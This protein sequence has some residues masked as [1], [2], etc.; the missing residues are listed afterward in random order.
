VPIEPSRPVIIGVDG[1]AGPGAVDLAAEEAGRRGVGLIIMHACGRSA[2]DVERG[3]RV[4]ESARARVRTFDLPVT[5]E[6]AHGEPAEE[7]AGRS[8][9]GCLVV[10]GQRATNHTRT[11]GGTVTTEVAMTAVRPVLVHRARRG[12]RPAGPADQPVLVGVSGGTSYEEAVEF[13]FGEAALRGVPLWAMS[14][15]PPADQGDPDG[16]EALDRWAEKYPSVPVTRTTRRTL[17][18]AV[19]LTAASRSAGLV[20]VG[21]PDRRVPTAGAVAEVLLHRAGC[22]VVLV[23]APRG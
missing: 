19:T 11:G 13:G 2:A 18:A 12:A 21:A 3:R 8:A 9:D 23:P 22:P 10:L 16:A 14:V 1:L 6:L 17:D 7:L 20:I 4:L 5:T 15:G